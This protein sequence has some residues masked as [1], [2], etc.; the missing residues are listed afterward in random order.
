[1]VFKEGTY[2]KATLNGKEVSGYVM[3]DEN[4]DPFLTGNNKVK[5]SNLENIILS[6]ASEE[7]I[8]EI[9]NNDLGRL[10]QDK[11]KKIKD[12]EVDSVSQAREKELQKAG[13]KIK[14]G[15]Y[16]DKF[17]AGLKAMSV[18]SGVA[19]G[20]ITMSDA[21]KKYES[22]SEETDLTSIREGDTTLPLQGDL[23]T[24]QKEDEDTMEDVKEPV[25]AAITE[26]NPVEDSIV[27]DE[28]V[29]EKD[30]EKVLSDDST[31][32]SQ[33]TPVVDQ[34][35]YDT[36]DDF[37]SNTEE[38]TTTDDFLSKDPLTDEETDEI[39]DV[40]SGDSFDDDDN[41]DFAL[42]DDVV[43]KISN[44]KELPINIEINGKEEKLNNEI[45]E[46]LDNFKPEEGEAFSEEAFLEHL[47]KKYSV[48]KENI[49]KENCSIEQGIC[50][51]ITEVASR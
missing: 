27:E 8:D 16:A 15:D 25:D 9:V 14:K 19:K 50:N 22:T 37:M 17:A 51:L 31:E 18:F 28:P 7:D 44:P 2:L 33:P 41:S 49:L 34:P 30:D 46:E 39:A 12:K 21:L 23:V 26:V 13:V 35:T 11:V 20:D 5:L 1:M 47:C 48:A 6:E 36:V 45:D 38:V 40:I 43:I 42:N 29:E 10:D 4:N 24:A 3:F 32:L